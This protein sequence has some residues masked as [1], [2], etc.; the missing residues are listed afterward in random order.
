MPL[1]REH[2]L[3][4]RLAHREAFGSRSTNSI[5]LFRNVAFIFCFAFKVLAV[6]LKRALSI[7]LLATEGNQNGRLKSHYELARSR[8]RTL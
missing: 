5:K 4:S 7:Y 6:R 2:E 3:K 8:N 1:N